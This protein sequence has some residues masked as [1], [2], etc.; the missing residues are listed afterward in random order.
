MRAEA[1]TAVAQIRSQPVCSDFLV[2]LLAISKSCLLGIGED[3]CINTKKLFG[4]EAHRACKSHI[5]SLKPD[6]EQPTGI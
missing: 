6:F 1:L 4:K 2:C 3:K 5:Q